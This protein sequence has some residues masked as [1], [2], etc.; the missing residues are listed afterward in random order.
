LA[1]AL[2]LLAAAEGTAPARVIEAGSVLPPGQSGFVPQSGTNPRL[3]DQIALFEDFRLKP[4]TFD[5]PGPTET[6]R[7]ASTPGSSARA[8]TP[9]SSRARSPC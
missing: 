3:T 5:Q 9:R 1:A 8:R 7:R 2:A 4:A 6:P